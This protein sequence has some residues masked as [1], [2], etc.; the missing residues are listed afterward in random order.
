MK[1]AKSAAAAEAWNLVESLQGRFVDGLK[2]A[3][4][5]GEFERTEWLRDSGLHGGGHRMSA[6]GGAFNR[7]S[8]NVSQ[9]HYDDLPDKRLASATALSTIIHPTGPRVPSVH[10]HISYTE[11]REAPSYWRLMADLNPSIVSDSDRERFRRAMREVCGPHA[12]EAEE[13]GDK[14]FFIPSLSRSRGVS[15][16]YLEQFTLPQ[17]FQEERSFAEAFGI[18]VIDSYVS[19]FAAALKRPKA[20]QLEE[21]TQ[22]EYHTM[23]LFQ[24]LTLDRGTTAGLLVHSQNDEG[25]LGSLP[26]RVDRGLLASWRARLPPPQDKLLERIVATLPVGSET[27]TPAVKRALAQGI[28]EHYKAHPEA[29]EMQAQGDVVPPTVP[30]HLEP[31]R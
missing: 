16:F 24:V 9:V 7:A 21:R 8:V 13:Q 4:P 20:S 3:A 6:E 1:Y 10:I 30:N 23:Y 15:H 19:I 26:K 18:R 27:I 31:P 17:G 14:Y 11:L 28:R 25:I 22:L 5:E 29:L 12:E 2:H